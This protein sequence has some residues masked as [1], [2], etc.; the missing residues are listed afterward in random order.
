MD[1]LKLFFLGILIGISIGLF[2]AKI[3][4]KQKPWTELSKRG[5]KVR[6]GA[7]IAGIV[8][9]VTGLTSFFIIKY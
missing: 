8:L 5:K 4:A 1:A 3:A 6:S 2:F 7:M 9:L